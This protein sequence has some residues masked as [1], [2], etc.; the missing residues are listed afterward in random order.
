MIL[1]SH[2]MEYYKGQSGL[3]SRLYLVLLV[4]QLLNTRLYLILFDLSTIK[5]TIIFSPFGFSTIKYAMKY[6]KGQNNLLSRSYL[7]L[8]AFQLFDI[9]TL[10]AQ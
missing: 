5:Y 1:L 4:F 8:L 3:L 2:A 7:V 10:L 6:Y 9:V